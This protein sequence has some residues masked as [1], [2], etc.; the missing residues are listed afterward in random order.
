MCPPKRWEKFVPALAERPLVNPPTK[1][2]IKKPKPMAPASKNV[3]LPCLPTLRHAI[4]MDWFMYS[5]YCYS[6]L[7]IALSGVIL[8]ARAIGYRHELIPIATTAIRETARVFGK[9]TG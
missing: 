5:S 4:F 9:M 2:M 1:V 8:R 7:C 6:Y 3:R